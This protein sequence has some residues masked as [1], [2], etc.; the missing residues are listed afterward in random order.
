M[1]LNND[2][3]KKYYRILNILNRL[4]NGPISTTELA[5]EFNVSPRSVQRDIERINMTG[6]S[7]VSEKRGTYSFA[8][9]TSLKQTRL[10][11]EQIFVLIMMR[12]KLASLGG[13]V[14]EAFDSIFSRIIAGT[15]A[16]PLFYDIN[17]RG[18]APMVRG[19]YDEISYAIRNRKY[20]RIFYPGSKG[21]KF[22]LLKP[23]KILTSDTFFYVLAV[24]TKKEVL[25]KYR[26]DRIKKIEVL[27]EEYNM[28]SDP[29]ILESL[30]D[31][32]SVW[33]VNTKKKKKITLEAKGQSAD[34]F[35]SKM[36]LPDQHIQEMEDGTVKITAKISHEMEVFPL[37]MQWLPEIKIIG[38]DDLKEKLKEKM[39]A[40]NS[41]IKEEF[42]L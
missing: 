37:I 36:A 30:K 23:L 6:F 5:E 28:P 18:L 24:P 34:F 26:I 15:D 21:M 20:I 3:D 17:T 39:I 2:S 13:S 31:A 14:A 19:I 27:M 25:L 32:T 38:P 11:D 9:G 40:V 4:N 41:Y 33:G 10:T 22:F 8:P 42:N 1:G 12:D 16:D 7:L 29:K 35:K